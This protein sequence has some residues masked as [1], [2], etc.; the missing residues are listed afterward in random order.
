MADARAPAALVVLPQNLLLRERD[1]KKEK[2]KEAE[3]AKADAAREQGSGRDEAMENLLR[4][5]S[6]APPSLAQATE[7]AMANNTSLPPL[8][9]TIGGRRV[10][11]DN[12]RCRGERK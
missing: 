8:L 12:Q 3:R 1:L 9:P 2:A 7:A 5:V 10:H 11:A 4:E 6:P